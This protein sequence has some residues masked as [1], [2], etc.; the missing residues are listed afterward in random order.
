[1]KTTSA[2]IAAQA[3]LH[4]QFLL[5][6]QLI[7]ATREGAAAIGEWMFRLFRRQ[8]EDKFLS[9]FAKLGLQGLPHAV[10][11]AR[12]HVLS[13]AVGGVAVEYMEESDTKAWVRF[14]Y[15]RWMYDGAAI[16]GVPIE[17]S[18]GFLRGWYAHNGVSLG[19]RRLGFV[20]VSEDMSGQF[21]LCG[22]FKEYGH[23]LSEAQRLVFAPDECPPP[24]DPARQPV[25]PAAEWDAQRLTKAKRN[26]AVEYIRNGV[27]ELVGVLGR[28]RA[29]ELAK[30]AARLTGLQHYRR[31]ADAVGGVDGGPHDAARFLAAMFEGMGDDCDI[32]EEDGGVRLDQRGLR[33]VRGLQ[34]DERADLLA[35]WIE[36]W[37]G[38]VHSHR[39]F[40]AVVVTPAADSLLWK[41]AGR[42]PAPSA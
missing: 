25:P 16:C 19:N 33:I 15:P 35:C 4:H 24:Y 11:C 6:L 27:R 3:E 37:R 7:V 2:A 20:C 34:G 28:A 1:M 18:R 39:A 5:G 40:M 13:N 17:A 9:S 38:A 12:Y 29:L 8:H 30:T 21:G 42:P 31:M 41:L 22:Y 36:I 32:V 26:Y 14:R 10:A 23:D